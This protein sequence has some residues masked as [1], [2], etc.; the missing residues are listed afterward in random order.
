M[1]AFA[2]RPYENDWPLYGISTKMMFLVTGR[3]P[4]VLP[5]GTVARWPIECFSTVGLELFSLLPMLRRHGD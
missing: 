5:L 4:M 1:H 3:N 2:L